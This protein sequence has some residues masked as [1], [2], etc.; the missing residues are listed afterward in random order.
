M[1]TGGHININFREL[2]RQQ[3]Y[4]F[5]TDQLKS[6]LYQKPRLPLPRGSAVPYPGFEL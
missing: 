2:A 1:L 5:F 6:V 3:C 4:V